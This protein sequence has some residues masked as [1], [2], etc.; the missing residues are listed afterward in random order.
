MLMLPA[1]STWFRRNKP[2]VCFASTTL[3][4][5]A[6][7]RC[8]R[9]VGRR[10]L[11]SKSQHHAPLAVARVERRASIDVGSG[12]TKLMVADVDTSSGRVVRTLFGEERTVS[13]ALSTKEGGRLSDMV[14]ERG[15]QVLRDYRRIAD[16]L[17]A[18]AQQRQTTQSIAAVATEVF[19]KAPN[20]KE[21]LERVKSETG[22]A[23]QLI[24]QTT[25]AEI[26]FMTAAAFAK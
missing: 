12:A 24:S 10:I 2:V 17:L 16:K 19:R 26:G 23:V 22:I 20:G 14:M 4:A 3:T 25:E 5:I 21:F 7:R 15:L 8:R 1:V 18:A 9:S 6:V 13:F 11:C